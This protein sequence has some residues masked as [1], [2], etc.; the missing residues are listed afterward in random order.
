MKKEKREWYLTYRSS[1]ENWFAKG[2]QTYFKSY[3]MDGSEYYKLGDL[4]TMYKDDFNGMWLLA[5]LDLEWQDVVV[6][7]IPTRFEK[8]KKQF[9]NVPYPALTTTHRPDHKCVVICDYGDDHYEVCEFSPTETGG[10]WITEFIFSVMPKRWAYI[11]CLEI[12]KE[13]E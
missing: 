4:G 12:Q 2:F 10:H 13:S 1:A 5:D 8:F 6:E 11:P 9:F 3:R 7:Y